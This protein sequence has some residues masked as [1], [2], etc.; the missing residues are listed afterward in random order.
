MLV[1]IVVG[2]IAW[3]RPDRALRVATANVAQTL[4]AGV[5]VSGQAPGRVFEENIAPIA[6]MHFLLPHLRY[7]VDRTQRAITATWHGHFAGVAT[8]YPTYGCALPTTTPDV[9]TLRAAHAVAAE[10]TDPQTPVV[11]SQD[12]A[13]QAALTRAFAEPSSG[14]QRRVHAIVVMH[15]GKI[16]AER[17]AAGFT[18]QTPQLGYSM[19]KSVVNALL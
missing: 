11:T 5:F 17:Y 3:K 7:T 4:C 13:I 19:S 12:P 15:D 1:L 2:L 14:P 10:E 8:W 9:E 6:G 18:A 16:I